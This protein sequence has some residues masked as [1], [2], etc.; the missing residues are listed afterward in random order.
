MRSSGTTPNLSAP[1]TVLSPIPAQPRIRFARRV[2]LVALLLALPC[3]LAAQGSVAGLMTTRLRLGTDTID[4]APLGSLP[5]GTV[6]P[7]V[8]VERLFR[9]T[10]RDAGTLVYIWTSA[11]L[12]SGN[13]PLLLRAE[14]TFVDLQTLAFHRSHLVVSTTSGDAVHDARM[15][16]SDSGIV[17]ISTKNGTNTHRLLRP[18]EGTTYGAAYSVIRSAPLREGWRT[19]FTAVRNDSDSLMLVDVDSVILARTTRAPAWAVYARLN[20]TMNVRMLIDT[21]TRHMH[22]FTLTSNDSSFRAQYTTRNSQSAGVRISE[23]QAP[24]LTTPPA[25]L[26]GVYAL[27]GQREAASQIVLRG[28]GT[29]EYAL[30]Y[31]ALDEYSTGSWRM[32][33]GNVLLSSKGKLRPGFAW[34][35]FTDTPLTLQSDTLRLES[36]GTV[37]RYVRRLGSSR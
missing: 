16:M 24:Q 33:N 25:A 34:H 20:R 10:G 31:G 6:P 13:G 30:T 29:F 11:P 17:F 7:T 37:L 3:S 18:A 8:A 5:K 14:T 32:S 1:A 22:E 9:G 27:E 4:I 2:S 19:T 26:A 21:T 15:T 36:Q 35:T 28:N 12:S 23:R